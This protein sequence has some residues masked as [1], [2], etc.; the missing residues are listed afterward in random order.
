MR[1]EI[2]T[3]NSVD[4][5]ESVTVSA[6][7]IGSNAVRHVTGR[8]EPN[9]KWS[10][11]E[12]ERMP[13]RLGDDVFA[14]GR[15]GERSVEVLIEFAKH[16]SERMQAAGAIAGRAV[17]TSAF[18]ESSNAEEVVRRVREATGVL[19]EPIDGL[20]EA[21]LVWLAVRSCLPLADTEWLIADLGGG[22]TEMLLVDDTGIREVSSIP[23]GAVRTLRKAPMEASPDSLIAAFRRA[24]D[25]ELR[26]P[27]PVPA[28]LGGV[29][30][31]GGNAE[32]LSI[33]V[34]GPWD[35]RGNRRVPVGELT[36]AI[37]RLARMT[38]AQREQRWQLGPD[39]ADVIL[40]AAVTFERLA[41]LVNASELLA[42]AVGVKEGL[43][44][45]VAARVHD[46]DSRR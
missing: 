5:L 1:S 25:A 12:A 45:D 6:L 46:A 18:R 2:E 32:A 43:L 19:I 31:T 22:S 28:R 39:R 33:V 24:T 17:A 34:D 30:I 38:P 23:V 3:L 21:R 26:L 40:P 36:L 7:D 14:S 16:F 35:D 4:S 11:I 20:E 42:P 15:I 13:L 41:K 8:V 9:G 29:A 37:E 44:V 10:V 27:W